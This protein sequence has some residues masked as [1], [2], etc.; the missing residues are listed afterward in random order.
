MDKTKNNSKSITT[1]QIFRREFIEPKT[2]YLEWT[3]TYLLKCFYFQKYFRVE[4]LKWTEDHAKKELWE[5]LTGGKFNPEEELVFTNETKRKQWE[6]I[7]NADR[8]YLTNN[9][10]REFIKYALSFTP[11]EDKNFHIPTNEQVEQLYQAF[12]L[13]PTEWKKKQPWYPLS[14]CDLALDDS[15]IEIKWVEEPKLKV[16]DIKKL[17]QYYR[18]CDLPNIQKIKIYFAKQGKLFT[19]DMLGK[20]PFDPAAIFQ[21]FKEEE[22]GKLLIP[23]ELS[24]EEISKLEKNLLPLLTEKDKNIEIFSLS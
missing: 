3:F 19:C 22:T 23:E 6:K 1:Y 14:Y 15:L 10:S 11:H 18:D 7:I 5:Q 20:C 17:V 21:N 16:E 13:I 4:Y 24:L 9:I 12:Q 8:N 2:G